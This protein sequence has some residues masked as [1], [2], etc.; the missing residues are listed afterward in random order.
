MITPGHYLGVRIG[1][2]FEV[3]LRGCSAGSRFA[4]RNNLIVN[5]FLS[6]RRTIARGS[7]LVVSEF[8]C[9]SMRFYRNNRYANGY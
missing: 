7:R 9:W 2:L 3:I 5:L 6:K 1:Y 4:F 8:S